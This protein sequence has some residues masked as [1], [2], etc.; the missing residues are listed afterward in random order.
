MRGRAFLGEPAGE[1]RGRG[2]LVVG[3]GDI[4]AGGAGSEGAGSEGAGSEGGGDGV[5]VGDGD[6]EEAGDSREERM[7]GRGEVDA[8]MGEREGSFR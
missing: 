7:T 8:W 4:S 3:F 6:G 1:R 5:G 2:G